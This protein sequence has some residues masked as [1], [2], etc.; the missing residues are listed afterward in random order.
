MKHKAHYAVES[1]PEF[2]LVVACSWLPQDFALQNA[3]IMS[4]VSN[5][6]DWDEVT[7]QVVLHSLTG[8]FCKVM[9]R[10]GW[11]N[12]PMVTKERLKAL[13]FQQAARA[14]G[15]VSELTRVS[16]LF[17]EA[18]VPVIPLKGVALSYELYGDPVIR[19]SGDVDI[20]VRVEDVAKAEE[21]LIALGY[22]NAIG[23]HSLSAKQ[24]RYILETEHHHEF[25]NDAHGVHIELHWR[26]ALWSEVQVLALWDK[27]VPSDWPCMDLSKLTKVDNILFLADHG[28]RHGWKCLKWLS[29][30]AMLL[31][32]SSAN[33]WNEIYARAAH[34]DLQRVLLE[35]T[36]L[37]KLV[38]GINPSYNAE[39]LIALDRTVIKLA[40][41]S[42]DQLSSNS[43]ERVSLLSKRFISI[44]LAYRLKQLKPS[45]PVSSLLRNVLIIHNDFLEIPLPDYF[46][47]LYL[48]LRPVFWIKRHFLH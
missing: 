40:N 24:Q 19:S 3:Q 13:R 6:D 27:I 36:L 11:P 12:V 41:D 31:E 38:Y 22:R 21:I 45:T 37:L 7:A 43:S 17:A 8:C 5:I 46:F 48:P 44:R 30:I 32:I 18:G 26:S 10:L 33:D 29:D 4:L 25:V 9:G 20:L 14:L 47:W 34:F 16:H 2:K 35:T 39:K 42:F 15:Q 28:A 1:A 23:F